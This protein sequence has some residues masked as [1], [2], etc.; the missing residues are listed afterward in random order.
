MGL[1]LEFGWGL[2][3]G[4]IRVGDSWDWGYNCGRVE[5]GLGLGLGF[6][7][8]WGF[9]CWENNGWGFVSLI[10]TPNS[11][12]IQTQSDCKENN[13]HI[14]QHHRSQKFPIWNIFNM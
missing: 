7:F 5:L 2:G 8:G 13:L 14:F 12:L 6:E 9:G 1:G 4:S 10:L 11:N 3:V